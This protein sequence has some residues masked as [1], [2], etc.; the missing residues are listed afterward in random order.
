M[1]PNLPIALW[2]V[3]KV[4]NAQL[5]TLTNLLTNKTYTI[6]VRAYT[7]VGEGPL[8]EPVKVKTT[9]GGEIACFNVLV[10][11]TSIF[12]GKKIAKYISD[13]G[14]SGSVGIKHKK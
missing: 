3:H 9:Q 10:F 2:T 8:S 14:K 4:D 5:T 12:T 7:S 13:I 1:T 11:Y 6:R